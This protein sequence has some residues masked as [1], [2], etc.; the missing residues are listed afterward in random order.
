MNGRRPTNF[1][2]DWLGFVNH[3]L[4][5]IGLSMKDVRDPVVEY[6]TLRRRLIS[7]R[8]RRVHLASSLMNQVSNSE[9]GGLQILIEITKNGENLNPHQ[10][11][12][13]LKGQFDGL[14]FGWGIHHLHLG[15]EPDQ[16]DPR[17]V[18]RTGPL[19][20]ALFRADD[21]CFIAL[22]EHHE[23]PWTDIETLKILKGEWP[24]AFRD[25]QLHGV[26]GNNLSQ[27]EMENLRKKNVNFVVD[28]AGEA[29]I[30][31]GYTCS[32]HPMDAVIAAS[33][34]EHFILE[35]ETQ[36]AEQQRIRGTEYHFRLEIGRNR[37][38]AYHAESGSTI[39]Q[40][41]HELGLFVPQLM[42]DRPNS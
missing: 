39:T 13:W 23:R 1:K 19:L 36:V 25:N 22:R 28:V 31:G 9:F 10:S 27:D 18:R 24:E 32:G 21:A 34:C 17:F 4:D 20:L 38:I 33:K 16:G 11:K 2:A 12:G 5:G 3:Q 7:A 35:F 37:L 6:F 29:Y 8:P 14:L 42:P 41:I 30:G 26:T 15:T 40:D